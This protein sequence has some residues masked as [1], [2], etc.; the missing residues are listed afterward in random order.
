MVALKNPIEAL[1]AE[2]AKEHTNTPGILRTDVRDA[3]K[4]MTLF[5]WTIW[6]KTMSFTYVLYHDYW[7]L[8]YAWVERTMSKLQLRTMH[9]LILQMAN[10]NHQLNIDRRQPL[11]PQLILSQRMF[12]T[13][14]VVRNAITINGLPNFLHSKWKYL[15]MSLQY[16][17]ET[18]WQWLQTMLLRMQHFPMPQQF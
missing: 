3:V 5:N 13:M 8:V 15:Q 10:N 6:N 14:P 9:P 11:V 12:P 1:V 18:P 4:K 7:H 16:Y 2:M 17:L